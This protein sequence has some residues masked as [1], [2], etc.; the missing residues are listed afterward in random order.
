MVR[1]KA[2]YSTSDKDLEIVCC[3]FVLY[4]MRDWPMKT[5]DSEMDLRVSLHL[6]QLTP[7]NSKR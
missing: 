4:E 5:H 1:A 7:E 2:M 3:F 6:A